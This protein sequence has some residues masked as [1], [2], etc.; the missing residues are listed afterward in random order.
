MRSQNKRVNIS[1]KDNSIA[2]YEMR[3]CSGCDV[4]RAEQRARTQRDIRIWGTMSLI[5]MTAFCA[6]VWQISMEAAPA[7]QRGYA[8]SYSMIQTA[9]LLLATLVLWAWG[10]RALEAWRNRQRR[11]D[12]SRKNSTG[13][14]I[15]GQI[16]PAIALV[17]ALVWSTPSGAQP[18]TVTKGS[19]G[20]VVVDL[21]YGIALNK[22]STLTREWHV[23][24]D[25]QLPL[26]LAD[27]TAASPKYVPDRVRGGYQYQS[28]AT[29]TAGEMAVRAFEVHYLVLDVFGERQRLLSGSKL[30]DIPAQ[31]RHVEEL[32]WNLWSESDA[33][34]AFYS[35]AW[36]AA[37]RTDNGQIYRAN[38]VEVLGEIQKISKAITAADIVPERPAPKAE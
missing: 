11:Q 32:K 3:L 33:A 24:N 1:A 38:T 16:A 26:Q 9:T 10:E 21:G 20:S 22:G 13:A 34:T 30:V 18:L 2:A 6:Y 19:S 8:V 4:Y 15:I 7:Y 5:A 27:G 17:V 29:L 25:P 28:N 31:A 36:V 14:A 35:I 23:I 37:V 12:A